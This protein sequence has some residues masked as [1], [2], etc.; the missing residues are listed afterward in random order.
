MKKGPL[1]LDSLLE[2]SNTFR[3]ILSVPSSVVF[4]GNEILILMSNFPAT[5][6]SSPSHLRIIL[7]QSVS[8]TQFSCSTFL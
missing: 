2:N 4:G 3:K 5:S 1:D 6:P 7:Q 8:P